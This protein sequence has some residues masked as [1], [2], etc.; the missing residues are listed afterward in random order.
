MAAGLNRLQVQMLM[1]RR[2][3]GLDVAPHL[4]YLSHIGSAR[5]P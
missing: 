2:R 4:D 3:L 1:K 5:S